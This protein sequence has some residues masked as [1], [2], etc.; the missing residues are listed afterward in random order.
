MKAVDFLDMPDKIC[1]RIEVAMDKK[2]KE[3]YEEFK[4]DMII[5][6]QG[7]EIDAINAA[8]L[9]N[10]LFKW[11]MERFMERTRGNTTKKKQAERLVLTIYLSFAL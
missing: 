10:K 3:L 1:N 11:L 9:S 8:G 6:L 4:R 7:D 2:E 5:T